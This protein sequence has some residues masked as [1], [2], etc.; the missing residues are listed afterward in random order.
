MPMD[1]RQHRILRS[2]LVE[3]AE[4]YAEA[5]NRMNEDYAESLLPILREREV[6]FQNGKLFTES[7]D[8]GTSP[9]SGG[10]E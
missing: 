7:S 3:V 4:L 6:R 2:S 9:D 8:S 5:I 1:S 10:G